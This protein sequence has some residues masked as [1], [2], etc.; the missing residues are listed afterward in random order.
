MT[1]SNRVAWAVVGFG[2][3]VALA[4]FFWTYEEQSPQE[5]LDE[6]TPTQYQL[7]LKVTEEAAW[8]GSPDPWLSVQ[9]EV[10][11]ATEPGLLEESAFNPKW[12]HAL[13]AG[14]WGS[15]F[16]FIKPAENRPDH[17]TVFRLS[18]DQA[19]QLSAGLVGSKIWI[20]YDYYDLSGT[21][22]DTKEGRSIYS[23]ISRTI[24]MR[25]V[26]SEIP[27]Q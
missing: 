21:S 11:D 2:L 1:R 8:V 17:H 24:E 6:L 3:V 20:E 25:M 19:N 7:L 10:A 4:V 5:I 23:R 22:L 15:G 14:P 18:R 26:V 27:L 16:I 13:F 9:F 12:A